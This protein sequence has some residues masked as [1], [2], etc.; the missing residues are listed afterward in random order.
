MISS[1]SAAMSLANVESRLEASDAKVDIAIS[2]Y[3]GKFLQFQTRIANVHPVFEAVLVS[4]PWA[5]DMHLGLIELLTQKIT[6][7]IHLIHDTRHPHTLTSRATLVRA[8]IAISIEIA[9]LPDQT[10]LKLAKG[11]DANPTVGDFVFGTDLYLRHH[12]VP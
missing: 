7:L 3:H 5:H 4:M 6:S 10:D 1:A 2:F 12:A 9:R 8:Q 11:N